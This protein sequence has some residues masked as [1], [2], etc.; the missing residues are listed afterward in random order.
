[1]SPQDVVGVNS[2]RLLQPCPLGFFQSAPGQVSLFS[3]TAHHGLAFGRACTLQLQKGAR[4]PE[5][6]ANGGSA[7]ARERSEPRSPTTP[8]T[9]P[10]AVGG[11]GGGGASQPAEQ[12]AP[13]DVS[14]VTSSGEISA[15]LDGDVTLDSIKEY[16]ATQ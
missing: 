9:T 5:Q 8:T 7:A 2:G 12:E 1:M 6:A 13:L 4:A 14:A 3:I 10:T 11:G 16:V 15:L